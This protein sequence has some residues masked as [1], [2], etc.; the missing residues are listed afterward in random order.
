MKQMLG[1]RQS[2]VCLK[3]CVST[4]EIFQAVLVACL[5]I[6]SNVQA[7][8]GSPQEI[9]T[10]EIKSAEILSSKLRTAANMVDDMT[11]IGTMYN[12]VD[13]RE[14]AC[15]SLG[16]LVGQP[17]S[18]RHIRLN[19]NPPLRARNS[20]EAHE[21]RVIARSLDN[22]VHV[23]SNSL[24]LSV[25]EQILE[26]NLDC[27]G[28]H[29]IKGYAIHT[30]RQNSFFLI[31]NNGL[32]LQILGDIEQGFAAR[33]RAAI[34]ANPRV[35]TVALGSGGGLVHEAIV[36]GRYIRSRGLETTLW[37][38]CYSACPLVF[39][40]GVERTVWS[41]YP[42]LGF[43]KFYTSSGAIPIAS[44]VYREVADYVHEMGASPHFVLKLIYSAEPS[45]MV[46][47]R[48]TKELCENKVATWIQRVC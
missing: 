8:S 43:H 36:A 20:D 41:P 4:S 31:K 13:A 33:L 34:E 39:L 11:W 9:L 27:V 17:E 1:L 2:I 32:V 19:R 35:N 7:Q 45:Q 47:I 48:G 29:G 3:P 25:D 23:A 24:K 42:N 22:F 16:L 28:Q 21:L 15:Y 37:N 40:G 5:V 14:H 38:N 26:W 18:V 44:R 12:E 46:L 6:G 30:N 10:S